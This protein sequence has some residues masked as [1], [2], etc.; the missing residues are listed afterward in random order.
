MSNPKIFRYDITWDKVAVSNPFLANKRPLRSH[1]DI[2]IFYKKQP[3][4]NKQMRVGTKRKRGVSK[5]KWTT[6]TLG[7]SSLP[8]S[9][10]DTSNLKNPNTVL[11]ISNANKINRLH[12]TQKPVTLFEY[13]IKTYTNE[14]ETVL[15]NCMGSGTTAIAAINTNRNYLGFELDEKYFELANDRIEK[16]NKQM[17]LFEKQ[18]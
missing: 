10:D 11:T 4:Y 16:H 1:E 7:N 18:E 13:L 9:G 12:P 17:E 5:S 3:T 8:N 14:G 6:G 2:L 15:D